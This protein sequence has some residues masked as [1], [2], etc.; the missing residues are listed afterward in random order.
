M[1]EGSDK[2]KVTMFLSLIVYFFKEN[3]LQIKKKARYLLRFWW[4]NNTLWNRFHVN[5]SENKN[6]E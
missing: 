3:I 4:G 6:R 1:Y 2:S 5:I